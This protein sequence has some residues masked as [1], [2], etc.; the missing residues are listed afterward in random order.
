MGKALEKGLKNKY[1]MQVDQYGKII[2][3]KADDDN[4]NTTK[5][6]PEDE[7]MSAILSSQL[8]ITFG[9]PKEGDQS[10]FKILPDKTI[11]IG[12]TWNVDS[13][14]NGQKKSTVYKVNAI[15]DA[16]II[17]DY[18]EE[19]TLNTKQQMMGTEATLTG[20]E[21]S[22]G[23]VTLDKTT[24]ILKSKTITRDGKSNLEAQ[25]MIIPTTEKT[26]VSVTVRKN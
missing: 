1:T 21:R 20:S 6:T 5:G 2:S 12:D 16:D 7:A 17:L 26:T 3:V 8:G 25:G 10:I 14:L 9:L 19:I 22:S 4:P 13:D 15:N 24:G 23:T 11:A 18:S